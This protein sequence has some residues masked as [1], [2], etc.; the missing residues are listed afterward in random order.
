[1]KQRCP[2][3][4]H[5]NELTAR[6]CVQ[7]RA[8]LMQVCPICGTP[9]SWYVQHCP[10]CESR[11]NDTSLFTELFRQSPDRHLHGRYLVKETLAKGRVTTVYRTVDTQDASA[12][13]AIKELS[14]VAL[15]RAQER[16]E[17][18]SALS[19]AIERW[20][21]IEHSALP[22]LIE[23]FREHDK[24]YVVSEFVKGWSMREIIVEGQTRVTPDLARNWGAQLC[25][26]I[27]FLHTLDPPLYVP[28]LAPGHVMVTS[29]G[30]VK[31]VGLGLGHLFNP[32][33]QNPYGSTHGYAAPELRSGF[34]TAQTDIFA[35]GRLLYALLIGR[36]L[37]KGLPRQLPLRRVVPGISGQLVKA[38]ARAAHRDPSQRF[39][40]MA[41]LRG[42]LW[43]ERHGPLEPLPDWRR[44][45]IPVQEHILAPVAARSP[46][47][48]SMAN[49]GFVRDPR[50]GPEPSVPVVALEKPEK[51]KL[52]VYPHSLSLGELEALEVKKVVLSVRNTGKAE[53]IGRVISHVGWISAPQK[54]IR[55]P[56]GKQAKVI[57]SVR[58]ALLP[59]GRTI[60]PQAL[61]VETN[62]GKQWVGA[63]AEIASGP[64]LGIKEAAL[65]FGTM[66]S[67][68]ERILPLTI[69]NTG[70]QPL[71]GTVASRLPWLR[72]P[73]NEFRCPPGRST[74]V[75]IRLLSGRLPQGP[76]IIDGG[77]VVDS[78]GGQEQIRVSAWR[79][80]PELDLGATHIDLG[81]VRSGE[82]TERYLYVGNAGDGALEGTVRSL[83]PWLQAWPQ[84]FRCEP[85]EM[86]QLALLA[87][88]TGLAD[89]TIEVPQALRVQTNAGART[90]SLRVQIHAPH[91]VIKTDDLDFGTVP[92]GENGE[93]R[94]IVRNEG[95]MPLT[96]AIQSL[97][98]W[99]TPSAT[100]I[101]CEPGSEVSIRVLASTGEFTDG[102]RIIASAALR[103]IAGSVIKEISARITILQPALR[104][105][106]EAIDFGYID[107]AQPEQRTLF[108]ANDGTGT[109]AWNMQAGAQWIEITPRSGVCA[110][111]Q[112]KALTLTAYGL[113]LEPDAE[114]AEGVLIINS[115][116]GRAKVP[117][118]AALAS[119]LLTTDSTLLDLGASVNMKDVTGSFR[120]FNHGLGLLKGTISTD[121]TW[122]VANRV[123]FECAMG[124]SI[125]VRV[126]TDMEEFPPGETSA[127]GSIRIQSNGGEI[128]VVVTI[129]RELAAYLQVPKAIRLT[130]SDPDLPPQGRLVIKNSGMAT[131]HTELHVG[132]PELVVS[133]DLCDIK[134]N[135]ST[136]ISVRLNSPLPNDLTQLYI[137]VCSGDQRLCVPVKWENS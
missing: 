89:G 127:G 130:Q 95:S 27:A 109:L 9:R 48:E 99:L 55:L 114:V 111:G 90:L 14:P 49:L 104:V 32:N 29:P 85:G 19:Q 15:F 98:S 105:E 73:R 83:L 108:V 93:E 40:S 2:K 45:E 67:D 56:I 117:L 12:P 10:H 77:L 124:R 132:T 25:E 97:A 3:C 79:A 92:L 134:P 118:R 136:R 65:D 28:F 18:E 86:V 8:P 1:M 107:P 94:L 22:R 68:A 59:S 137:D 33:E 54:T 43:G 110:A 102:Q 69:S 128:E 34:P 103:I 131:A 119:P 101:V 87:D 7:C 120:I 58:A 6:Q 76:Q 78:D 17:A 44:A 82:V 46:I 62:G 70:R 5:L 66:E 126:S 72:V 51:A 13:Y 39:A 38:I 20:S 113:A 75:R 135:K 129:N 11:G 100:E 80:R 36:L 47:E 96:A 41:D 57:L 42:A 30:E 4:N 71:V 23:I 26:L 61:S 115:D 106:P 122:L 133:R 60:E 88:C 63:T 84:Q 64:S 35:L 24:Y 116:G 52:S 91:M 16:R 125:E 21:H 53:L 74:Q 112:S 81:T 50:F 121:Q 123:S 37:E 31:L